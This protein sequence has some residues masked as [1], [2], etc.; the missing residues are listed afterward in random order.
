MTTLPDRL[1]ANFGAVRRRLGRRRPHPPPG[2][3]HR[4]HW[5]WWLAFALIAVVNLG[6]M[7]DGA[8]ATW[9]P[10][11]TEGVAAFFAGITHLG[12]SGWILIITGLVAIAIACADWTVVPGRI[13]AAWSEIGVLAAYVFFSVG[14]AAIATNIVKQLIGRSR[15]AG[16]GEFGALSLDP[17]S[18]DYANES[19]PSGHATT[20]GAAML[21]L[22]LILPR[23]TLPIAA[24]GLVIAFS[25]VMVGAHYP[26]D[27]VAGL[28]VGMTIAYLT[29]RFLARRRTGFAFDAAGRLCA[30]TEAVRRVLRRPGASAL[31]AGLWNALAGRAP[32]TWVEPDHQASI[33]RHPGE[34]RGPGQLAPPESGALDSGLRN[35]EGKGSS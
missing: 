29:A 6:V 2:D 26:S 32:G 33:P 34:G 18:F 30:K 14:A 16:H 1:G 31:A 4:L 7:A 19:F 9:P 12:R 25:R 27:V 10:S 17:F 22:M 3:L 28:V 23:L 24:I 20:I 5:G 11:L 13:R 35:D 8:A 21:A 15:P